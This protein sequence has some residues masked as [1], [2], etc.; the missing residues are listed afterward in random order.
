MEESA[1][2]LEDIRTRASD[3]QGKAIEKLRETIGDSY[4]TLHKAASLYTPVGPVIR[5]YGEEL[6]TIQPR[7]KTRVD[8][9]RELASEYWAQEGNLEQIGRAS[10]RDRGE[11]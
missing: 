1:N 2:V 8:N 10:C 9:C 11:T 6:E 5:T 3:Q 4:E 7:I